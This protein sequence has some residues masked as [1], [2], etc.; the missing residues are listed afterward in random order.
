M[1]GVCAIS[2]TLLGACSRDRG[3]EKPVLYL[4]PSQAQR[5]DIEFDF[6]GKVT[7]SYPEL[8]DA[9]GIDGR[10]QVQANTDGKLT[11][12]YGRSYPYLF[13]EGI[14][15]VSFTQ[16]E[17]TVVAKEDVVAFLEQALAA[18]GLNDFE[19]AD[20]ITY[21]APRIQE[22]DYSL[23]SFVTDQYVRTARYS[24]TDSSGVEQTPDTFIR[25]YMVFS[26][27]EGAISV[28]TQKVGPAPVRTGFT[29]VEWGGTDLD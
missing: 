4:Y 7:S 22:N 29:A 17:G 6:D 3:V 18:Q 28:P 11:D 12:S 9:P 21:W 19:A 8:A 20:F 16:S 13:W 10:W 1:V 23:I 5:L 27:V 24:F 2:A 15:D 14:P 25:V 26:T